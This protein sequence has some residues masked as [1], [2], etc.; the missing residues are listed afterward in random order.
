MKK[1]HPN[2][3]PICKP[4]L[5]FGFKLQNNSFFI[6]I[7]PRLTHKSVKVFLSQYPIL[8]YYSVHYFE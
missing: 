5:N 1:I 2:I 6:K 4:V 8:T 7:I 3:I